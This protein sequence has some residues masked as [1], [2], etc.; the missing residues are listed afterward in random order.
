MEFLQV[1]KE[2]EDSDLKDMPVRYPDTWHCAIS[3]SLWELNTALKRKTIK[4]SDLT[5]PR[6][7]SFNGIFLCGQESI[8]LQKF[9]NSKSSQ[10][11]WWFH[12][13]FIKWHDDLCMVFFPLD[14]NFWWWWWY[15]CSLWVVSRHSALNVSV[16]YAGT[17]SDLDSWGRG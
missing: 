15:I 17:R 9:A 10:N 7:P 5:Y 2:I 6:L 13:V 11:S 8:N 12:E 4:S 14:R 1:T 16:S 3:G